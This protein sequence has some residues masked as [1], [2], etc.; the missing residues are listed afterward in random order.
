M[1]EVEVNSYHIS[2]I[3]I[4]QYEKTNKLKSHKIFFFQSSI[5]VS[6]I[7]RGSRSPEVFQA[8]SYN[9]LPY[10]L[11]ANLLTGNFHSKN[12]IRVKQ[13]VLLF[14]FYKGCV[15]SL[16]PTVDVDGCK[17]VLI[18][19]LYLLILSIVF[20]IL[21]V[22]KIKIMQ[23]D[24]IQYTYTPSLNIVHSSVI[25]AS[26]SQFNPEPFF[27]LFLSIFHYPLILYSV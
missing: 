21:H 24:A 14:I 4:K 20:I 2:N 9:S 13:I 19:L 5:G 26:K 8:I 18:L 1:L 11:L 3:N 27:I 25:H 6:R 16:V 12:R 15:N 10:F 22:R 7:M 23:T 17:A